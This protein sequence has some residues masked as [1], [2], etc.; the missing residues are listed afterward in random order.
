MKTSFTDKGFEEYTEWLDVDRKK[1]KKISELIKSIKRDGLL[2][3][4]GNPERLKWIDGYSREIDKANRLVYRIDEY[5]NL[6]II[7]C[8]G[9]YNDK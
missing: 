4:I 6:E 8:K 7:S 3:G 2:V 9:H 5:K 1:L